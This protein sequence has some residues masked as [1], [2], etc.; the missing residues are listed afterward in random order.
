MA[1]SDPQERAH[2]E[3]VLFSFREYE[4]YFIR[5]VFR[6][7]RAFQRLSAK[8]AQLLPKPNSTLYSLHRF[9]N[10]AHVNQLFLERIVQ[11]QLQSVPAIEL[12][13]INPRAKIQ[14]PP[15]HLSKLKS[16]L[17]QFVRDWS[18]EGETERQQCYVP[19]IEELEKVLPVTQNNRNKQKVLVPG[20]GLGRLTLEIA[21]KGYAAQGNEF[22]YQMLFASN[23]ILNC[24]SKKEEFTIHPWIHNSSN[25]LSIDDALRSV[26]I[27]DVVPGSLFALDDVENVPDFSMCAGEFLEAYAKDTACWDC[28]VTCF[29]IDA[30]PNVIEYIEAI[31]RLLRPGGVWINLGP[32]LYHWQSFGESDAE[33]DPRYTQSIELSH[34]EIKT[35]MER[36]GFTIQREEV[37]ECVYTRNIKSLM[38]TTYN[39]VFF[40]A[41]RQ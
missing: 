28:I 19:I 39:C 16:T 40:T 37:K 1:L 31:G 22:S 27:P 15:R 9:I 3:S 34:E 10:A 4:T 11:E 2:Y 14:S 32:L 23:F 12:P 18:V 5:E 35:V 7:K 6:R 17:H 25:H 41:L 36:I 29:F 38:H 33:D 24:I 13:H 20:A 8:H 30:A 26:A 21:A